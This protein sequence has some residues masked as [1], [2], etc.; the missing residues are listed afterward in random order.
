MKDSFPPVEVQA[1]VNSKLI[2]E[3]APKLADYVFHRDP[4]QEI[5]SAQV[6]MTRLEFTR[7]GRE[8][9]LRGRPDK[10]GLLLNVCRA[11]GKLY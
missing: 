3:V 8:E 4:A 10:L 7:K 5:L 9:F 11:R 2:D 1:L 6:V